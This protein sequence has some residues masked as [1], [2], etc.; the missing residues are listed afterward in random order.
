MGIIVAVVLITKLAVATV[1]IATAPIITMSIITMRYVITISAVYCYHDG[2][3]I[4]LLLLSFYNLSLLLSWLS[5]SVK[6]CLQWLLSHQRLLA[7]L[8]YEH[9][10]CGSD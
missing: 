4:L 5:L 10:S 9:H 6:C 1:V 7:M 2:S 3:C 8:V